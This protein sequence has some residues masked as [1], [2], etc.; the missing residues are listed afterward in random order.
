MTKIYTVRHIRQQ[1]HTKAL[2]KNLNFMNEDKTLNVL[3]YPNMSTCGFY[4]S[5][6]LCGY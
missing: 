6:E 3:V 5:H 4:L 1:C 2:K